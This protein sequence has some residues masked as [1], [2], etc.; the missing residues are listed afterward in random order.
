MIDKI[1]EFWKKHISTSRDNKVGKYTLG[2]K[3]PKQT[4]I[5]HSTDEALT[6][7]FDSENNT[8][9]VSDHNLNRMQIVYCK[10][11]IED[12]IA[13]TCD[14]KTEREMKEMEEMRANK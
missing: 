2:G 6:I 14:L 4:I 5:D 13:R 7:V 3:E 11:L 12:Q 9:N 1:K 10:Y 8:V